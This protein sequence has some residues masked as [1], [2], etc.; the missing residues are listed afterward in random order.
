MIHQQNQT[1]WSYF[2]NRKI[3][4][5]IVDVAIKHFV[6]I[7][8]IVDIHIFTDYEID[9]RP[10]IT[11]DPVLPR[12]N[13]F[14]FLVENHSQTFIGFFLLPTM[15][16][17]LLN[18]FLHS[19]FGEFELIDELELAIGLVQESHDVVLSHFIGEAHH[20]EGVVAPWN[21]QYLRVAVNFLFVANA[22][23]NLL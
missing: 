4:Q 21:L 22:S 12:L 1:Y 6:D 9:M 16:F 7:L 23:S 8:L 5:L 18:A 3:Q 14:Q 20:V 10:H 11:D 13:P 15:I 17:K 2:G 19:P